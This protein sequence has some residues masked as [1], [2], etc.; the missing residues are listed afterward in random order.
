MVGRYVPDDSQSEARTAC[1]S[2]PSMVHPAE[3]L[4]DS[5]QIPRRDPDAAV[6]YLDEDLLAVDTARA[7]DLG[8]LVGEFHGVL[9]QIGDCGGQ[10]ASIAQ[11]RHRG[12]GLGENDLDLVLLGGGAGAF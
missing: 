6:A 9:Q 2:P 11:H 3:T 12:V 8:A 1:R 10:L 4:E 5:L 7:V